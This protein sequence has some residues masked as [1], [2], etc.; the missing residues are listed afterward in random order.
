M[1]DCQKVTEA[2]K[3]QGEINRNFWEGFLQKTVSFSKN[4]SQESFVQFHQ[5]YYD[6][7]WN[8]Y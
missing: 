7:F 1:Y 5:I 2:E 3:V 4:V 6:F 8:L